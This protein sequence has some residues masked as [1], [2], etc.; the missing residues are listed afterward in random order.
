MWKT[1]EKAYR[2]H[3][4]NI[5]IGDTK[6]KAFI[7]SLFDFLMIFLKCKTCFCRKHTENKFEANMLLF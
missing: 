6:E 3:A 2:E 5:W 1:Y 4:K 7:P